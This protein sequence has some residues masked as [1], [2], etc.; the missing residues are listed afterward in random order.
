MKKG[1]VMIYQCFACNDEAVELFKGK[2]KAFL[3]L[4]EC[5]Q[6]QKEVFLE[7]HDLARLEL[8]LQQSFDEAFI[9]NHVVQLKLDNGKQSFL[10]INQD[11]IETNHLIQNPLFD[12]L[13]RY[14]RNWC[15]IDESYQVQ[16]F[17]SCN[18]D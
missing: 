7:S 5:S 17:C 2:E 13:R 9:R 6:R 16:W 14:K 1:D 15:C 12:F 4:I 8:L 10:K 11:V 18:F 3:Y